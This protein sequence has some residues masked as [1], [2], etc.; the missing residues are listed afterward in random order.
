MK[1]THKSEIAM[2]EHGKT[3]EWKGEDFNQTIIAKT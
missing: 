1:T 2:M 3:A